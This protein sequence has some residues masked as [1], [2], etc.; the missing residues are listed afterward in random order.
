MHPPPVTLPT[1]AQRPSTASRSPRSGPTISLAAIPLVTAQNSI[2]AAL[3]ELARG[4]AFDSW[5]VK[6]EAA[7]GRQSLLFARQAARCGARRPHGLL[8]VPQPRLTFT[9]ASLAP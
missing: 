1:A 8:A 7:R 9:L 6:G 3:T 5:L 2:R 4:V